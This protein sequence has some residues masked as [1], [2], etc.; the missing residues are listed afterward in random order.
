MADDGMWECK[1]PNEDKFR[2]IQDGNKKPDS[3]YIWQC[4]MQ[5]LC[6]ERDWCDLMYFHPE[7]DINY[8]IFRIMKDYAKQEK[9]ILGLEKGKQI[10]KGHLATF[11]L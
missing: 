6:A 1:C 8:V 9:L 5:M 4:Q 7:F 2:A 11:N 3:A 10:L